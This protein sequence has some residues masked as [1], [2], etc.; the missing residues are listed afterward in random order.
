MGRV[1]TALELAIAALGA[2]KVARGKYAFQLEPEDFW[3]VTGVAVLESYGADPDGVGEWHLKQDSVQMRDWWTP[4]HRE[5]YRVQIPQ[6]E[7]FV[8]YRF[9]TEAYADPNSIGYRPEYI[10]RIT[11]D[12]ETGEEQ[13]V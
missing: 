11:A 2:V 1:Q 10:T 4:E 3:R 6:G 12:L 13:I 8:V 5:A 9:T 7:P